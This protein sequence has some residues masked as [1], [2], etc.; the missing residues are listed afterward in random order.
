MTCGTK[1]VS[2]TYTRVIFSVPQARTE[3]QI[4][5]TQ[6]PEIDPILV[7]ILYICVVAG[8]L[9]DIELAL[10]NLRLGSIYILIEIIVVMKYHSLT[11]CRALL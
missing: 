8:F 10:S 3:A 6:G 11:N 9:N 4:P 5:K 7:Q 1:R 2:K